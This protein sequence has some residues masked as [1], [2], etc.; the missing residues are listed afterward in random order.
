MSGARDATGYAD[1]LMSGAT[2]GVVAVLLDRVAARIQGHWLV[3]TPL[4]LAAGHDLAAAVFLLGRLGVTGALPS[5]LRLV[6][7]RPGLT[8]AACSFLGGTVFMGGYLVAGFIG[9]YSWAIWYRAVR[10]IGVAK[11]MALNITYAMWGILLAWLFTHT[12]TSPLVVTGCVVVS[13]GAAMVIM[14]GGQQA[15]GQSGEPEAS[16][17]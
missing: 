9:G 17:D 7:S 12:A 11:A 6:R 13:V 3:E 14:S 15:G 2:W 4:V 5:A 16:T 10:K 8:I 1:G